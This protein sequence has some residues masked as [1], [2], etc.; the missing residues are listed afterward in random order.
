MLTHQVLRV[1]VNYV[2]LTVLSLRG[3]IVLIAIVELITLDISLVVVNYIIEIVTTVDRIN[4]TVEVESIVVPFQ[5]I[6]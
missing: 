6:G 3:L 4:T 5:I 2:D 1:P